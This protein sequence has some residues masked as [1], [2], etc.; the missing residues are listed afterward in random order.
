MR[1]TMR[2]SMHVIGTATVLHALHAL[3]RLFYPQA[4]ITLGAAWEQAHVC[5]HLQQEARGCSYLV[6]WLDCDREGEN[7][8]FEVGFS[9]LSGPSPVHLV[10]LRLSAILINSPGLSS[11]GSTKTCLSLPDHISRFN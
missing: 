4:C 6:L 8:C 3:C 9:Q 11:R 7:I 1:D 2:G 10:S 5:K